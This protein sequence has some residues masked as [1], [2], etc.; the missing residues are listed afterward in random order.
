MRITL[1]YYRILNVSIKADSAKLDQAYQDRLLQQPCREY[2]SIA[3][4]KRK[5]LLEQAYLIL[6]NPETRA[7][8]D[9]NFFTAIRS[10]KSDDISVLNSNTELDQL[11]TLVPLEKL[12][13]LETISPKAPPINPYI[14]IDPDLL[15]GALMIFH[16]LAEYEIVIRLGTN[17]LQDLAQSESRILQSTNS[18]LATKTAVQTEQKPDIVLCLALSYLDLSRE[19]WHREE[20]EN[21]ATSGSEGLKLLQK[22]SDSL[23]PRLQREIEAELNLLKPYRILELLEKNSPGSSSRLKGLQL[24]QEM[25]LQREEIEDKH[26]DISGLKSDQ[27]LCFIQQIRTYLTL[28]EQKEVFLAETKRGSL[29]GSCVAAYALIAEGYA[30]KK[31]SSILQAQKILQ[32]LSQDEPSSSLQEQNLSSSHQNM[33]WERAICALLLGQTVEAQAIIQECR[34]QET[35][36]L[37]QEYSSGAPD[38]LP[39]LCFYGQEWLQKKVLAQFQDLKSR[40]V[41]FADYFNDYNVQAYI[42]KISPITYNY[43]QPNSRPPAT[44]QKTASSQSVSSVNLPHPAQKQPTKQQTRLHQIFPWLT[45]KKPTP[46]TSS[47]NNSFPATSTKTNYTQTKTQPSASNFSVDSFQNG[48]TSSFT[49]SSQGVQLPI[50]TNSSQNFSTRAATTSISS[51]ISN[52]PSKNPAKKQPPTGKSLK[53]K[54][55]KNKK[56]TAKK[57]WQKGLLL[58]GLVGG[59]GALGFV[60]TE[61]GLKNFSEKPVVVESVTPP[62]EVTKPKPIPNADQT[63]PT[64]PEVTQKTAQATTANVAL[65]SAKSEV[66]NQELARKIIQQW[67]DSKAAALGQNY[68]NKQLNSILTGSILTQWQETSK[69]YQQNNIYRQFEH[70]IKV[71]SYKVNPTNS[72]LA[73]VEAEVQETAKH[74]QKGQIDQSQSYSDRLLV[75]YELMR[76][77]NGLWLIKSSEVVQSL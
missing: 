18:N 4:A 42:E 3:I 46:Q 26:Q 71:R 44:P 22:E 62:P 20:F 65:K 38:L 58:A 56:S 36:K 6:S 73:T 57:H 40:Q 9:H 43:Q 39:G 59:I 70:D 32:N 31:P 11:D 77:N 74:Y 2:S 48:V 50:L 54:L 12:E 34:D 8:Y 21:S 10:V 33:H 55:P 75:R 51:P 16:E 76:Q 37:I 17:F 19:Q 60:L 64:T 41:T 23:F 7:E 72:N 47:Q 24:L 27:F 45:N 49:N 5:E 25:L 35:L 69:Y 53:S 29:P 61:W 13:N 15:V 52:K 63:T 1:D 30:Y 14:E 66:F 67:L 68:Q 28:Q